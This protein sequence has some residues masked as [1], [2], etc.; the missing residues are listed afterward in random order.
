MSVTSSSDN[1]RIQMEKEETIQVKKHE[2]KVEEIAG[3]VDVALKI[4]KEL[5]NVGIGILEKE[6]QNLALETLA[7]VKVK[8]K[9][10]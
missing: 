10:L 7:I 8:L 6:L 2:S 9:E 1:K 3:L 4:Q 5:R